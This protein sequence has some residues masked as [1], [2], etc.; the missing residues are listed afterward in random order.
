MSG[1]VI[2]IG[3]DAAEPWVID[4][5]IKQGRMPVLERMRKQGAYGLVQ[6]SEIYKAEAAFTTF[7]TGV[8]PQVTGYWGRIRYDADNL[9]VSEPAWVGDSGGTYEFDDYPMFWEVS[10]DYKVCAFDLPQAGL[11]KNKNGI[12]VVAWGAH[13]PRR[14]RGSKPDALYDEILAA[15]GPHP[16]LNRDNNNIYVDEEAIQLMQELEIGVD[17]RTRIVL[18]LLKREPWDLFLTTFGEVH[19]VGHQYWH[20]AF[21]HPL[22]ELMKED[23]RDEI[24]ILFE[25]ID[26]SIGRIEDAAGP[27]ATLCVYSVH[28]MKGNSADLCSGGFLAEMLYRWTFNEPALASQ[29][30]GTPPPPPHLH[31][32]R[33]MKDEIWDAVTPE[34]RKRLTSPRDQEAM[35]MSLNWQPTNW[36][37]SAWKDMRAFCLPAYADGCVRINVKGRDKGGLVAPEDFN[38]VCDEVIKMVMSWRCARTGRGL[39]DD[40]IRIRTD[41]LANDPALPGSDLVIRWSEAGVTDIIES[42]EYGQMGPVP[43]FR[44]GS[45][46]SNGFL[47]AKGP[48]IEAGRRLEDGET[49]DLATTFLARIGAPIPKQMKGR[50]LLAR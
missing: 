46:T 39:V 48:G 15:Y 23:G 32:P 40:V 29:P 37:K 34:G 41:A 13:S 19:A 33:H 25:Q 4:H 50:D 12:E 8:R 30:T 20:H 9:D 6:N 7:M 43:F 18:D 35:G 10:D 5:Y 36:Y 11:S 45:H 49:I 2:V 28:G 26:A 27:D 21:D 3:L 22:R 38:A 47:L 42:D 14:G 1:Q 16:A 44:T 31:Y 17:R 24:G